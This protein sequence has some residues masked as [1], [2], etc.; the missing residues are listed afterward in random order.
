MILN[1]RAALLHKNGW[2]SWVTP[3]KLSVR[4]IILAMLWL[5]GSVHAAGFTLGETVFVAFPAGNIK[6]DAF[7]IGKVTRI[8]K[9]GD[10]QI[11]V[12]EYVEGHDYGLSCVP[13]LKKQTGNM[14]VSQYG[15]AW[16][17]WRDKTI[18]EAE[19]L[20]YLVSQESVMTLDE[21]KHLFI[22]RNN[23]FIV[24]GRWKSDAPM[25]TIDRVER[26]EGEV[27]AA[28]LDELLPAL[29]LVKLH[30]KSFYGEYGRPY[31]PFETIEPL[32]KLL[33]S[34]LV[35]FR[36]DVKLESQWRAKQRDWSVLAKD[37]R[38]YF[39]I[40]AIDKVVED[41]KDQLYEEGVEQASKQSISGLKKRLGL[42]VREY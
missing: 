22:E 8:D 30:R 24:F 27:R 23:L 7:I 41:A 3:L 40:E 15:E 37:S 25:L 42:L 18:L 31:L 35:L 1:S 12:L 20:D 16:D 9:K 2:L 5:M 33:D 21:G 4:P 39:L 38:A 28:G 6:D 26:A 13:M 36:Q 17:V 34:V 29:Q 19:K 14:E 32:N 11:S 10:Y